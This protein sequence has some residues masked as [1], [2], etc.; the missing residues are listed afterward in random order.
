MPALL[1]RMS[2]SMPALSKPSNA[3]TTAASSV[4]SKAAPSAAKPAAR[5]SP[6]AVSTRAG[7]VPLTTSRAPALAMPSAMARP[8]PRLE[9]VTSAVRPLRSKS[10]TDIDH[11]LRDCC[12]ARQDR[13]ARTPTAAGRRQGPAPHRID[14]AILDHR[15]GRDKLVV[16]ALVEGA[17]RFLDQ[18]IRLAER[19]VDGRN[20][21]DGPDAVM[22]CERPMI[23]L[24]HR[25]DLAAL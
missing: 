10:A 13:S 21:A 11:F 22:R 6:T 8:S 23:G 1:T 14:I 20:E 24:G 5:S 9:P 12:G 3:L 25:R 7:S 16:P 2:I 4:T 15:H 17:D 19:H 18:R